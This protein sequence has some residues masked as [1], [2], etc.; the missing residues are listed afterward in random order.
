MRNETS[1]Q[2]RAVRFSRDD[3]QR[4]GDAWGF[5]CGPGAL[6]AV[7]DMT[8]D[9]IRPHLGDFEPKG[10]VNPSLMG[11]ILRGLNVPHDWRVLCTDGRHET[12][13]AL[14]PA[15][16]RFGLVRIQWDGPWCDPG[17]PIRARYRHTHW[18]AHRVHQLLAVPNKDLDVGQVFDVN[19]MCV[20][21]W[22]AVEEWIAALV[23]WLLQEVEPKSSGGWWMTHV[24]ELTADS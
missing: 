16:P 13:T 4:A 3:A 6:C 24:V 10:Y 18:V 7:L 11:G 19:A 22:L 15:W 5:N 1:V 21:G 17:R 2:R 20:G 23:P 9:E 14:A 12:P 8:P